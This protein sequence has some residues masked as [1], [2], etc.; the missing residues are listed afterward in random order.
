MK[1]IYVTNRILIILFL[2]FWATTTR[3]FSQSQDHTPKEGDADYPMLPAGADWAL[4]RH[5]QKLK[6]IKENSWDL[7]LIGNSITQTIGE[8]GGKYEPLKAVWEKYFAPYNAI[9]LGFNGFRTE[10]ILWNLHNGEL[11]FQKSP[12]LFIIL[13]G[14]NNADSRHFPLAHSPRQIFAGTKAIVDLIRQRHPSSKILVIRIFPKGLDAQKDE[15]TSPPVFSFS[16]SDVKKAQKAGLLTRKLADGQHVFWID[17][18]HVFLRPDGKINVERMP[19]LLH[20]DLAGTEAWVKAIEP[21]MLK[22]MD[23][24]KK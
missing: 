8:I 14:T 19:D 12:K 1:K 10:N 3:S 18:N 21:M 7:V 2:A 20:P 6:A 13:I 24:N 11:D 16:M 4:E 22:L 17:V 23:V 15:A 5:A 9:N